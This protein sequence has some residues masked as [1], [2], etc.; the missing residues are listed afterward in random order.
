MGRIREVKMSF[1]VAIGDEAPDF[2]LCSTE[3]A[4]VMLRDEVPRRAVV[5]YFFEDPASDRARRDLKSL[6]EHRSAL[7]RLHASVLAVAPAAMETLKALCA[8]LSLPFPL[9]RDDRE[10]GQRYGVEESEGRAPAPALVVVS[11]R[12]RILWLANPVTSVEDAMPQV[13]RIL[14]DQPS[15]TANYPRSIVNRWIDRW[16]N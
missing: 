14:K 6:R 9:L 10:F 3:D 16:V 2:D 1:S 13:K 8:D 5:L 7:E 12:Q 11:R 4:L 15:P